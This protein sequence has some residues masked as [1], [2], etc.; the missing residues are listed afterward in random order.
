MVNISHIL[1]KCV[2]LILIIGSQ[3]WH[4]AAVNGCKQGTC[5][6]H[7]L[8]PFR[9]KK[10]NLIHYGEKTKKNLNIDKLIWFNSIISF[11]AVHTRF[12]NPASIVS[13]SSSFSR[14]L[15]CYLSCDARELPFRGLRRAV[16]ISE[17]DGAYPD[18]VLSRTSSCVCRFRSLRLLQH[19]LKRNY[20]FASFHQT[21]SAVFEI[22]IITLNITGH[23]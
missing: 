7:D 6:I 19:M 4:R 5:R 2:L 8:D 11:C 22:L 16:T 18:R 9:E 20:H 13:S 3:N 17:A 12:L 21:A 23:S 14:W 1:N 10:N 15:V